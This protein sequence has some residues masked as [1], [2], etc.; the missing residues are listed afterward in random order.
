MPE[1]QQT[2]K[3][4]PAAKSNK[5][6]RDAVGVIN[7]KRKQEC[8]YVGGGC[9]LTSYTPEA[10]DYKITFQGKS[11]SYHVY[12]PLFRP[13]RDFVV[14]IFVRSLTW[15]GTRVQLPESHPDEFKYMMGP[16]HHDVFHKFRYNARATGRG[17]I[18]ECN[19]WMYKY[20]VTKYILPS[21]K[22]YRL[23]THLTEIKY[24]F[25]N[26]K[27]IY[28]VMA[29]H[30]HQDWSRSNKVGGLRVYTQD[31]LNQEYVLLA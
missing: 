29:Y 25:I 18:D 8:L 5:T 23:K 21:N 31:T 6:A 27:R 15:L 20:G 16:K 28:G 24:C 9:F 11:Y 2:F 1:L 7:T 30:K 12:V 14:V 4:L 10:G 22:S 26:G 17:N 19:Q 13:T 3:T